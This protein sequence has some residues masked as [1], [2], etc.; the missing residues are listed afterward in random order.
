MLSLSNLL[1]CGFVE[2]VASVGF[3]VNV[4]FVANVAFVANI[5]GSLQ[6]DMPQQLYF[7]VCCRL[8]RRNGRLT[9][10]SATC[11]T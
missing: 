8:T 4:V 10:C 7:F 2:F 5:D 9:L 3:V 11:L 6:V 1:G